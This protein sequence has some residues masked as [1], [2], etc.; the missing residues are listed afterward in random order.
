MCE[1]CRQGDLSDERRLAGHVG[2]GDQCHRR[3]ASTACECAVVG[4]EAVAQHRLQ[5]GVSSSA[6][7]YA[8]HVGDFGTG[9]A[10]FRSDF[11]QSQQAVDSSDDRRVFSDSIGLF[12]DG[13]AQFREQFTLP[14]DRTGFGG[15]HL[16]LERLEFGRDESFSVLERLFSRE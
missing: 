5:N 6:D 16:L 11:S 3:A 8:R 15:E 1:Q 14:C 10:T 12:G 2:A 7:L 13:F 9:P 4:N